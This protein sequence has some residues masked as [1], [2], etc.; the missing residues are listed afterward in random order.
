MTGARLVAACLGGFALLLL[1]SALR[2]RLP[3]GMAP[4]AVLVPTTVLLLVA[5]AGEWRGRGTPAASGA[6]T[7]RNARQAAR[8]TVEPAQQHR[9]ELIFLGWLGMLIATC[10]LFGAGIAL[11]L[12]LLLWFR[13][14]AGQGWIVGLTAA[15]PAILL[16]NWVLPSAVGLRLPPGLVGVALLR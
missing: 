12:F 2:L 8:T 6:E 13:F 9:R 3:A 11:P 4:L 14:Q 1:A 16:L 5:A 7:V 10:P 15:L